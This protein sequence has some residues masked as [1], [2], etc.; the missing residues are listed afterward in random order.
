MVTHNLDEA[1][2]SMERVVVFARPAKVLA[3]FRVNEYDK[4][5][6]VEHKIPLETAQARFKL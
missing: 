5:R 2:E 1:L 6:L 3:D 4:Q